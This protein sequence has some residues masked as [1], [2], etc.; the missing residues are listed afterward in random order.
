MA[1]EAIVGKVV[2]FSGQGLDCLR[3]GHPAS[4]ESNSRALLWQDQH[5]GRADRA[6]AGDGDPLS[7]SCLPHAA[8]VCIE[9]QCSLSNLEGAQLEHSGG[10][11]CP[12]QN[13]KAKGVVSDA[14]PDLP[15][16]VCLP[17]SRTWESKWG[18]SKLC[19]ALWIRPTVN[20]VAGGEAGAGSLT[21]T[22]HQH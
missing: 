22:F 12:L 3:G 1:C 17:L 14:D 15:A 2:L 7:T 19:S 11:I 6:T 18:D 4:P 8:S 9:L 16:R 20:C 21:W 10:H 13:C 5:A